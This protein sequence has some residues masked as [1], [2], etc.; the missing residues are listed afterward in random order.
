LTTDIFIAGASARA[1]AFSALRAG[2]R[3]RCADLFADA[4][5]RAVCPVSRI[6]FNDYP[7]A[8]PEIS[9]QFPPGPWM[10]GGAIEN[11]L[12]VIRT[13]SQ[14]RVLWGC[15]P[16]SVALARA[17]DCLHRLE[18]GMWS[19]EI[20]LAGD[21]LP[22]F[23]R[24][25][26]KPIAG[27]AGI[28]IRESFSPRPVTV[29]DGYYGQ[30]YVNGLTCSAL[31]V[32]HE[33]GSVFLGATSQLVGTPWLNAP[34]F[35]YAGSVGLLHLSNTYAEWFR[36]LGQEL[37]CRL[38]LRGIYGVDCVL[39]PPSPGDHIEKGYPI[40]TFFAKGDSTRECVAR[41]EERARAL[42]AWLHG[43]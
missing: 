3:P 29:P 7:A 42:D 9:E 15:S 6:S 34:G 31:F 43:N 30:K 17:P 24:W 10:Y 26:L 35:K 27:A 5:L 37:A 33:R 40:L 14:K 32:G 8:V 28:G 22:P 25:L 39:Q 1:A 13:V 38:G 12:N 4:D 19:P 21:S 18:M 16:E 41:L 11:H 36:L 23:E 2:L 20:R